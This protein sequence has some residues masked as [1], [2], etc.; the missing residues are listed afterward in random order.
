MT[1]AD[2]HPS[3]PTREQLIDAHVIHEFDASLAVRNLRGPYGRAMARR[4]RRLLRTEVTGQ[5]I[6][7]VG[8]G[9]GQFSHLARQAGRDVV[10]LDVDEASIRIAEQAFGL[11]VRRES[12]Y[13]TSLPAGDRDSAVFFDSIQHL[14]LPQTVAELNRLGVREV[15]VYDSNEANPLLR[16]HRATAGHVEAHARSPQEIAAAF[17][18][19]GF[20]IER[21]RYE[22]IF[23][24][25]VTGGFQRR[26]MPLLGRL[27]AWWICGTDRVLSAVA[28]PL[29]LARTLAFRWVLVL[30]R[31]GP[32]SRP[33]VALRRRRAGR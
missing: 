7:D 4:Y 29:G 27:P 17:Q 13:A 3:S 25:A 21:L 10:S 19:G 20:A 33:G 22:N 28:R 15:V 2:D 9:F 8:C 14:D 26:P 6:L 24:L 18:A 11:D 30:R 32:Q 16:R 31:P 5:R 1:P 23:L 12:V